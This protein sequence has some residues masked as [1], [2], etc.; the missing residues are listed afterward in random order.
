MEVFDS[1][2]NQWSSSQDL[3]S[4]L[5]HST[6]ISFDGKIFVF[7]GKDSQNPSSDKVLEFDPTNS[8]WNH[9]ATMPSARYSV[10]LVIMDSRI[11][12]IGGSTGANRLKLVESFDPVTNNWRIEPELNFERH[13]ASACSFGSR[14]FVMGGISQ[15]GTYLSSVESISTGSIGWQNLTNLPE[16]KYNGD[17]VVLNDKAY[18]VAGASSSG[19]YSNKVFAADLNASVAGVFDVY[20]KTITKEILAQD[21]LSDL[22]ATI[23]LDRL[24]SE[25]IS[26]LNSSGVEDN[27]VTMAKLEPQLRA[28]L[29]KTTSRPFGATLANPYGILGTPVVN[30]ASEYTVPIGKVLVITGSRYGLSVGGQSVSYYNIYDV[31]IFPGATTFTTSTNGGWTGMIF[32]PIDGIEPIVN[33]DQTYEVP[34]GKMLFITSTR[35]TLNVAGKAVNY[36]KGEVCTFPSG[37][38]VSSGSYGWT[39]YLI[40]PTKF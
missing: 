24:S 12:L 22:N 13:S 11:W 28:D 38:I 29:N 16:S 35:A 1:L 39:G 10:K 19:V 27:S 36:Q 18:V 2:T 7:G 8:T 21:I 34:S 20:R 4:S 5:S 30:T 9:S 31:S 23:G 26:E 17:A 6:A 32:D 15:N 37:T 40:D 14:I 3:P 25:A 33:I